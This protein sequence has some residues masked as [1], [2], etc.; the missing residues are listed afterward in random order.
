M[1]K[2]ATKAQV[3]SLSPCGHAGF[4]VT[5]LGAPSETLAGSPGDRERGRPFGQGGRG[6]WRLPMRNAAPPRPAATVRA[7][8]CPCEAPP[9][10]PR[11]AEKVAAAAAHVRA[12][13]GGRGGAR[14]GGRP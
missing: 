13:T 14:A 3:G 4:V 12:T 11:C 5:R 6:E 8:G 10:K 9:R 1:G 7:V 2:G